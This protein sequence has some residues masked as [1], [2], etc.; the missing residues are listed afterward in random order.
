[1][2]RALGFAHATAHHHLAKA[3]RSPA[4]CEDGQGTVEYIGLILLLAGVMVAVVKSG[5]DGSIAKTIVEKVKGTIDDVGSA[6]SK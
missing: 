3:R 1:M 6:G 5:H 2:H 4:A